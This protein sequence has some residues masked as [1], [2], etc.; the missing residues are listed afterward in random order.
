MCYVLYISGSRLDFLWR[1]ELKR[2]GR[3]GA[4]LT[5]VFWRFCQTR[6][7]VAIFS[8]LLTMVAG[9][10][11]PV[12]AVQILLPLYVLQIPIMDLWAWSHTRESQVCPYILESAL[13]CFTL[14]WEIGMAPYWE[15]TKLQIVKPPVILWMSCSVSSHALVQQYFLLSHLPHFGV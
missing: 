15:I 10:V 14:V 2:R 8:L 3:D 11:G 12:S 1:D 7:L 6:M 5:R 9:F 4:S 13:S